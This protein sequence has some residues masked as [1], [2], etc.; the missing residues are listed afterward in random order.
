MCGVHIKRES[1]KWMEG[2]RWEECEGV[3]K[4]G[5]HAI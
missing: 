5:L 3:A 4:E 2:K 1:I